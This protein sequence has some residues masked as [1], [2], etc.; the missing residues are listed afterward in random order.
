MVTSAMSHLFLGIFRTFCTLIM[1]VC[2]VAGSVEGA[3]TSFLGTNRRPCPHEIFWFPVKSFNTLSKELRDKGVNA[4][5][6]F[7]SNNRKDQAKGNE[8]IVSRVPL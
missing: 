7:D 2:G 3:F 4:I 1:E 8:V 5:T 6:L